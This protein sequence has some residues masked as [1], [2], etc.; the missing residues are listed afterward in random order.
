MIAQ[1]SHKMLQQWADFSGDYNPIHFDQQAAQQIGLDSV[2][3][4]GMLAMMQLKSQCKFSSASE[5]V[6]GN[7]YQW[8]VSLRNPLPVAMPYQIQIKDP[9]ASGKV[10]FSLQ[11]HDLK[12]KY[13]IGSYCPINFDDLTERHDVD[14]QR[15]YSVSGE[16]IRQKHDE[17]QQQFPQIAELWIFL[18]GLIFSIFMTQHTSVICAQELNDFVNS[19]DLE[20]EVLFLHVIHSVSL[21][22]TLANRTISDVLPALSYG[23]NMA[24]SFYLN[25]SLYSRFVVPVWLDNGL[26]MVIE[27]SMMGMR[28][29]PVPISS[30]Q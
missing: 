3:V 24:E 23:I 30:N 12:V 9:G 11:S 5:K 14:S 15:K 8:Q 28:K 22:K 2:A 27:M 25:D 1:F 16:V 26:S 20:K 21:S 7:G 17:F 13:L 6:Q 4:H 10:T 18:E 19:E 29:K